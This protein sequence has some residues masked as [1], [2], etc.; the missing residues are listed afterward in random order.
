LSYAWARG[1]AGAC[2]P[3]A[4]F[5]KFFFCTFCFQDNII[6]SMKY[7]KRCKT[8]I[9]KPSY[10]APC[11]SAYEKAWRAKHPGYSN[12][13][14]KRW[15]LVNRERAN[16][17]EVYRYALRTGKIQRGP[18]LVC[19]VTEGVEGHHTDYTKP[20]EVIWLC[21]PHHLEEHKRIRCE[22]A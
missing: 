21:R 11:K 2:T 14:K 22:A 13:A 17:R 8:P 19:G 12:E 16:A 1:V 18:C 7:C 10:C 5:P 3:Q 9:E 20:L 4:S 15:M 6:V